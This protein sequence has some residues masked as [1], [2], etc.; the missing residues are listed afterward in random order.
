VDS[1][2]VKIAE[3]GERRREGGKTEAAPPIEAVAEVKPTSL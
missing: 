1:R 2:V 3:G